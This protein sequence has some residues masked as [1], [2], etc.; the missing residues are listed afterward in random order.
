MSEQLKPYPGIEL[1]KQNYREWQ[2]GLSEEK[3]V[4]YNEVE[5]GGA[6]MFCDF[7]ERE[8]TKEFIQSLLREGKLT[9][10][11]SDQVSRSWANAVYLADHPPSSE[12]M[13]D[14]FAR[15]GD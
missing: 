14:R 12:P 3:R 4:H 11:E 1:V 10:E 5:E 7:M 2:G 9:P 13:R 6:I 8:E 15:G